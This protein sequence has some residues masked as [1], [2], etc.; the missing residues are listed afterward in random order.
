MGK[1]I[2]SFFANFF[3]I[4]DVYVKGEP[5]DPL[6][7]SKLDLPSS[8]D[9]EAPQRKIYSIRPGGLAG[10]L[11]ALTGHPSFVTIRAKT[12]AYIGFL[13]KSSMDRM[14]EKYPMVL[15]ALGKRLVTEISPLVLHI[16][17][18]LEWVQ[19][20]AGKVLFRQGDKISDCVYVVLN[21]RLRSIEERKSTEPEVVHEFGQ[22]ESVGELEVLTK[23]ARPAT[24]HA[25]RDTELARLP[26]TLFNALALRHPEITIQISR[27]IASR[28]RDLLQRNHASSGSNMNLKTVALLPVADGVPVLEFADKLRESLLNIGASS[29]ILDSTSVTYALGKHAFS[30]LAKLKIM[31]WLTEHEESVRLVIY[32]ADLGA[33]NSWTQWCIRQADCILLLG[34]EEQSKDIGDIERLMLNLK[35]TA[36]KELVI[37][38]PSRHIEKGTTRQWLEPRPWIQAHHHVRLCFQFS[39]I[40]H[41]YNYLCFGHPTICL[42]PSTG[43]HSLI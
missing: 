26:K 19:V 2:L 35:T 11:A 38:H 27:L 21:G 43:I 4:L 16:D 17:F 40:L 10:Y 30:R 32:V 37:L 1:F 6:E 29:M 15:L 20:N 41:R 5:A 31:S 25:I 9:V 3:S 39:F 36:R 7:S 12:D 42:P 22:G 33:N 24:V 34:L 28:S 18:A 14:C 23:T 8:T 13:S